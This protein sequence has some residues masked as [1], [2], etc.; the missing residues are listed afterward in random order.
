MDKMRAVVFYKHGGL[1]ELQETYVPRPEPGIGEVLVR[2]RAVALNHLDLWTLAGMPGLKIPLP[3]ILGCDVAG[4]VAKLGARLKGIPL[5]RP[6]IVSPGLCCGQCRYCKSGWDSLCPHYQI[7]GFQKNGG[8]AQYVV[9]AKENILPVSTRLSFVQ[10]A[11]IPLV[12]LTAWHMLVTRAQL[13]P[14]ETVLIH[15][16]GSGVGSA[17]IQIARYLGA[18]VITTVGR[19]EKIK[20]AKALGAEEV[21][22]YKKKDFFLEVKRLTKGEGVDVVLEH[23]GPATFAKSLACLKKQGRLVTCGVTS[24]PIVSF[25]LRHF[26]LHQLSMAGCYLGGLKEL[27]T[28]IRLVEKKKLHPVV[29]SIYPLREAREALKKMQ[30]RAQFGKIVLT[31]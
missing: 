31:P 15:S 30:Q 20:P 7:L 10:W 13:K 5:G 19:D 11:A 27:K 29:D 8:L 4:E 2:V 3:H 24:G 9:V 23:I 25:D 22:N 28:V 26:F 18:H 14:K 16:A 12:F 21:I 6:V 17:A 1:R